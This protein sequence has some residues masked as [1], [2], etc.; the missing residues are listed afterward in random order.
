MEA[1]LSLANGESAG[2]S[3]QRSGMNDFAWWKFHSMEPAESWWTPTA[4]YIEW[5]N[6]LRESY[7]TK[8]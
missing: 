7:K 1:L 2:T 6:Q 5:S 3:S 4:I 8:T